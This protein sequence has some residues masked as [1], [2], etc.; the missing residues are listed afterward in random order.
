MKKK[1]TVTKHNP[2]GQVPKPTTNFQAHK[3]QL[4]KKTPKGLP[5]RNFST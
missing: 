4:K 1:K 2:S 5:V 3:R